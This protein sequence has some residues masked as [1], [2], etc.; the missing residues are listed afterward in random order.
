LVDNKDNCEGGNE[1]RYSDSNKEDDHQVPLTKSISAETT[2][3]VETE[4]INYL[5]EKG[6]ENDK[7]GDRRF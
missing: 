7:M 5:K 3:K 1:M 4:A 6:S 2:H